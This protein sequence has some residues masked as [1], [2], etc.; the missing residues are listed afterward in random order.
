MWNWPILKY[1]L[2][3][4]HSKIILERIFSS[5]KPRTSTIQNKTSCVNLRSSNFNILGLS[6]SPQGRQYAI[7]DFM[8]SHWNNV[9]HKITYVNRG[10]CYLPWTLSLSFITHTTI[11]A[12]S[13]PKPMLR[14]VLSGC[15]AT[16]TDLAD[17]QKRVNYSGPLTITKHDIPLILSISSYLSYNWQDDN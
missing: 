13:F 4:V 5:F 15:H 2:I 11:T 10:R 3:R 8:T 12:Q 1:Q 7:L 9:T 16:A 17:R 6:P 14:L